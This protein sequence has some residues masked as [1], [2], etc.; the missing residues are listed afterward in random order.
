MFAR[1]TLSNGLT[2]QFKDYHYKTLMGLLNV[3]QKI[4]VDETFVIKADSQ[5]VWVIMHARV[6]SKGHCNNL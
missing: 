3:C 4:L 5:V 2:M 6:F 1:S